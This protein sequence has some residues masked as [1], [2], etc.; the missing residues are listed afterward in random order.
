MNNKNPVFNPDEALQE[1]KIKEGE[2]VVQVDQYGFEDIARKLIEMIPLSPNK[3]VFGI[4]G[5]WGTG[6]TT[7]LN[8]IRYFINEDSNYNSKYKV[9]WFDAWPYAKSGS[10]DKPLLAQLATTFKEQ[11]EQMKLLKGL[12]RD[13]LALSY[14]GF[15]GITRATMGFGAK[16]IEEDVDSII[17]TVYGSGQDPVKKIRNSF[18]EIVKKILGDGEEK[19]LIFLIDN[20]DRCLPEEVINLLESFANLLFADRCIFFIAVDHRVLASYINSRYG[21]EGL[22]PFEYLEKIVTFNFHIPLIAVTKYKVNEESLRNVIHYYVESIDA[23]REPQQFDALPKKFKEKLESI[24]DREYTSEIALRLAIKDSLNN[25]ELFNS[26]I[27]NILSTA[28]KW[29]TLTEYI[30][31]RSGG[32]ISDE[33]CIQLARFSTGTPK[34]RNPRLL[35]RIINRILL[36][37]NTPIDITAKSNDELPMQIITAICLYHAW[38]KF[39]LLLN[40]LS[41]SLIQNVPT[42]LGN[43]DTIYEKQ[44]DKKLR[45]DILE[46]M[47]FIFTFLNDREFVSF[48]QLELVKKMLNNWKNVNENLIYCGIRQ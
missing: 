30:K 8:F 18:E 24:I 46:K 14:A 17:S 48:M 3:Y 21:Q 41:P 10:L 20:M 15:S 45:R 4:Y 42:L 5:H 47:E 28:I 38:P 40:T 25:D 23:K 35:L 1:P 43:F 11:T 22:D 32:L 37:K 2:K 6:K 31:Q 33:I 29:E 34:L 7:M 44:V 36:L 27:L 12:F 26:N 16:E 19:R 13:L 9:V 39:F